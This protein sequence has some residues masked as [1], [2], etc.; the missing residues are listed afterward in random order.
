M[1]KL[2]RRLLIVL[3][4]L[5]GQTFIGGL[6]SATAPEIETGVIV[7][8]ARFPSPRQPALTRQQVHQ[9]VF[10]ESGSLK[11]FME[12]NSYG[13]ETIFGEVRGWY[14]L[15]KPPRDQFLKGDDEFEDAMVQQVVHLA[16]ND[17][18]DFSAYQQLI[19]IFQ[20]TPYI[21]GT[22]GGERIRLETDDF[23]GTK[24]FGLTTINGRVTL[25]VLA[26]EFG[27]S[28]YSLDHAYAF[29]CG[30]AVTV[31]PLPP[32]FLKIKNGECQL[33]EYEDHYTAMGTRAMHH[34]AC[35]KEYL[36]WF[37]QDHQL[38]EVTETGTYTILPISSQES[39]IK[40]IK[41]LKEDG[42][43]E[44][45]P[46]GP[47]YYYLEF[48]Q[49][50]GFD[51]ILPANHPTYGGLLIHQG[52]PE[53]NRKSSDLLDMTPNS[54]PLYTD[55]LIENDVLGARDFY[56]AALAVDQVYSDEFAGVTIA[57]LAITDEG[58][59]VYIEF[60]PVHIPT[61]PGKVVNTHD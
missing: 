26:H 47:I 60:H 40:A 21:G 3:V 8:L 44:V 54:H 45:Q 22:G 31:T 18:V 14:T 42:P 43:N 27:H 55:L 6:A 30:E 59:D 2:L 35:Y 48:R 58:I 16:D 19:V 36:E 61:P 32:P 4:T 57:P 15:P 56:D 5:T 11:A 20:A 24:S 29:E 9:M 51:A 28:L 41:I 52:G 10:G 46:Q 33:W 49:P 13:Q 25:Y 50:I 23:D 7:L 53:Y 12:E 38:L 34:N 39:G 17:G 1:Q 37:N